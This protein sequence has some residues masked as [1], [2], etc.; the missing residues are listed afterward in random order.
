ML[1]EAMQTEDAE[2]MFRCK[3]RQKLAARGLQGEEFDWRS[4]G[5]RSK[6]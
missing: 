1:H 3:F 2:T 4:F 5:S 6:N